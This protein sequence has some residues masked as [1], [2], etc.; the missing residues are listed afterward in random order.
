MLDR[1][2][3]Q[4]F[5]DLQSGFEGLRGES[6]ESSESGETSKDKVKA[7]IQ[8][9]LKSLDLVTREEFDAQ[10]A[11]LQKSQEQLSSLE[12]Q[13]AELEQQ[14]RDEVNTDKAGENS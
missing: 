1:L 8:S 13:I 7:M 6:G 9:R 14:L 11:L 4:F 2:V 3:N 12:Q 10:T 5:N